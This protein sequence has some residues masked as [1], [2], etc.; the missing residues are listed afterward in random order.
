MHEEIIA[1]ACK[2]EKFLA[3]FWAKVRK[4]DGCWEWTA[5]HDK[6][7]YGRVSVHRKLL[8]SCLAPRVAWTA[9]NGRI[10]SGMCILHR[11]DNPLCIRPTHL[12][13]GT[14]RDNMADM[15]SKGRSVNGNA[16]LTDAA[17][18]SIRARAWTTR[19]MAH[20]FGQSRKPM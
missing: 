14:H 20:T 2:D 4:G 8:P 12:Y 5:Y 10:P 17:V 11:C 19:R 6:F 13:C 16:I 9:K 7:G 15:A 1:R 18:R 3:R